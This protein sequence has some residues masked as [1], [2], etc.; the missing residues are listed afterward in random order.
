MA[1]N[2]STDGTTRLR[3]DRILRYLVLNWAILAIIVAQEPVATK[4]LRLP[5]FAHSYQT[6]TSKSQTSTK[7]KQAQ[8][9][10]D[11]LTN[12]DKRQPTHAEPT[13]GA[14]HHRR[15]ASGRRLADRGTSLIRAG[16]SA[17]GRRQPWPAGTDNGGRGRRCVLPRSPPRRSFPPGAI[18][19]VFDDP[20]WRP[21]PFFFRIPKTRTVATYST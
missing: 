19:P 12:L 14:T 7:N 2:T 6:N 16:A 20:V 13:L 1:A 15:C 21:V 8:T 17:H 10:T 11:K 18:R 4:W 9:S 3:R 5:H